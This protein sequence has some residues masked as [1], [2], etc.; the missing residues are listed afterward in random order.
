MIEK[1]EFTA[2][3]RPFFQL[4]PFK[5]RDWP[6]GLGEVHYEA[7]CR[8]SPALLKD[9]LGMLIEKLDHFPTPK[10]IRN[11]ITA[12]STSKSE[13]GEGRV[14]GT[15]ISEEI[16]TRYLEHKHG[17]EY[18]GVAVKCPDPLP[19]WIKQEVDRVDDMLGP[20]F[21]VK[22]KLGNVGFAIVQ[23]ENRG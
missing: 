10:D 17:V 12:L 7:F 16:A 21:P 20:Q 13:G 23:K 15:S 2:L 11:Q 19:P 6:E 8:E 5:K 1:K 4:H 14:D 3:Y 9:A 22:S 18:N